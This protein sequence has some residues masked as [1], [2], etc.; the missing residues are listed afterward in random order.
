MINKIKQYFRLKKYKNIEAKNT[1]INKNTIFE[2]ENKIGQ[3]SYISNSY[4]GKYS[5]VGEDCK[6]RNVKIG[7]YCSIGNNIKII[8][9][10]HP[11]HLVG[12]HP[13]FYEGLNIKK[14]KKL[15]SNYDVV[16]EHDVWI[17][18]NVSIF[19]GVTIG[20]GSVIGANALVIE[21]VEPY[22][23]VVGV[24]A[25]I[26]KYRFDKE[27]IKQIIE[28][29]WWTLDKDELEKYRSIFDNPSLFSKKLKQ[30]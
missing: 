29:E 13:F 11:L 17:G 18:D 25:K 20:T 5:Y 2:G 6:L 9:G 19:P 26:K 28:T 22:S 8:F 14:L 30:K 21:D 4:F 12:M 10:D 15:D 1:R 24:P 23:V 16:I 3:R 27:V 7:K